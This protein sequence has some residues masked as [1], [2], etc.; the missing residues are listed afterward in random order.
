VALGGVFLPFALIQVR[1]Y[2]AAL[3]GTTFLPFTILMAALSRWAGGLLDQ[4]GA[5]LPLIVGPAI[6]ALG[7]ALIGL[8]FATA[9]YWVS[10]NYDT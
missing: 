10:S 2:P 6:A 7:I 5:R 8:T 3:A 1:G 9:T 4:F